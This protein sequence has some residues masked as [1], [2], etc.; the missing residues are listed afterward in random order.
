MADRGKYDTN[1]SPG[2]A[3]ALRL[4]PG[5]GYGDVDYRGIA[6]IW[7]YYQLHDVLPGGAGFLGRCSGEMLVGGVGKVALGWRRD[8]GKYVQKSKTY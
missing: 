6:D 8:G 7:D 5:A 2:V 1:S 4:D 3:G